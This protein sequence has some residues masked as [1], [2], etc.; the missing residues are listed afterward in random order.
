[1]ELPCAALVPALL[2]AVV[3]PIAWKPWRRGGAGPA[4]GLPAFGIA[5]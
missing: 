4:A 3:L 5:L 1:L 2:S